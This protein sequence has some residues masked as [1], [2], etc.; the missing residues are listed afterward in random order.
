MRKYLGSE[1]SGLSVTKRKIKNEVFLS[2]K[3]EKEAYYTLPILK[4]IKVFQV[5]FSWNF[6]GWEQ[7][8]LFRN[9]KK[10]RPKTFS[11]LINYYCLCFKIIKLRTD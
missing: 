5:N 4:V 11:G 2:G 6:S 3:I 8:V 10:F 1:K 7:N 9:F